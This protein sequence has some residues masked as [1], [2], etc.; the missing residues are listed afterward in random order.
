MVWKVLGLLSLS[1]GLAFAAGSPK[2]A[3]SPPN[4]LLITV[5]TLRADHLSCYGYYLK[6][7]PNI[8]RL[9]SEGVRFTGAHT[10]IP[11]TGPAHLSLLTSR[12]PQEHGARRNGVAPPDDLKWLFLP[13][14]LRGHGYRNAAFVSAWPL[15]SRLTHLDRW[16]DHYDEDLPRSYHL[17]DS[18]RYAEDVT[19]RAIGWLEQNKDKRFFLW[20]HYFDPHSPYHLRKAYATPPRTGASEPKVRWRNEEMRQ[21]IIS[22]D[23][24]VGYADHYIGELLETVDRLSLRDS[25]LVVLTADHGESLGE[26]KYVGHGRQLYENIVRIPL[27]FRFPGRV[28]AGKV[29]DSLVSIIDIAPTVFDLALKHEGN[30]IRLPVP[31]G[32]RSLA[33]VV[34]NGSKLS[35]RP[36]RYVTFAGKKGFFP[37]FLSWMWIH[38]KELPLRMGRTT[39]ASKVIWTPGDKN[40]RFFDLSRDPYELA[41]TKVKSNTADYERETTRLARWFSATAI[42]PNEAKLTEQDIEVL[43]SLGYIQ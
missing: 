10:T 22:Y 31:F 37:Q 21:R 6:T 32:G 12:H 23:S 25:T 33:S 35:D 36:A 38:E 1:A 3:A 11:L 30:G 26:H 24:E 14:I 41:P 5:D 27:I 2:T 13:Q 15:T 9:A 40:L 7:S 16:F 29:V 8:D 34:E 18:M 17:F 43:K 20:V 42:D 4:V 39:G 28:Q 19:P